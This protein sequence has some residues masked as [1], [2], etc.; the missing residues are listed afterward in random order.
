MVR[1]T[2]ETTVSTNYQAIYLWRKRD[3]KSTNLRQ[4]DVLFDWYLLTAG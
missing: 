1:I 2:V 4:G 3:I